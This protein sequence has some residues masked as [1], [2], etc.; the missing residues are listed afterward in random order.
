[1]PEGSTHL[2]RNPDG[3]KNYY[4]GV[5]RLFA[6]RPSTHAE[7]AGGEQRAMPYIHVMPR[8]RLSRRPRPGRLN[9]E[10]AGGM[11]SQTS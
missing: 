10:K 6:N 1:M 2:M 8:K 4:S 9:A 7:K 5:S 3:E 11:L